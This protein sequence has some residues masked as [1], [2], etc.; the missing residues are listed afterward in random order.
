MEEFGATPGLWQEEEPQQEDD[1]HNMDDDVWH[2]KAREFVRG[3]GLNFDNPD[4]D[5][6]QEEQTPVEDELFEPCAKK[7]R[8]IDFQN[9][10]I[11][12]TFM[13]DAGFDEQHLRQW[14]QAEAN[15]GIINAAAKAGKKPKAIPPCSPREPRPLKRSPAISTKEK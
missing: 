8:G 6:Q 10:S 12:P 15:V 2:V 4:E 1:P 14:R 3:R 9:G 5:F 11:L 13:G 7:L